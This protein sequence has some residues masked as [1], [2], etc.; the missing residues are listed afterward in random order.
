MKN[1]GIQFYPNMRYRD[2]L[3]SYSISDSCDNAQK[4]DAIRAFSLISERTIIRFYSVKENAEI[5]VL[6]S[7]IAPRPEEKGH[8]V[9]GEGGPSEIY[10]SSIYAVIFSGKVSLFRLGEC[11]APKVAIHEIL[12]A[13]GF[14][15][16]DNQKSIMF[17]LTKCDQEIDDYIINEINR[18]YKIDSASDLAI[19][20]VEAVKAGIYL[21]FEIKIGNFGLHDSGESKLVIYAENEMVSEISLDSIEIGTRKILTV[22]NI[23]IPRDSKVISFEIK[24]F[25]NDLDSDNNKVI[26]RLLKKEN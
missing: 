23:K 15:H 3:I 26:V 1:N 17:P 25:E 6:C 7:D 11:N 19:E 21:S 13:L 12:H 16:N 9:A 18:L 8:F 2:R 14:D 24:A 4:S 22:Q 10:N 5:N 20:K